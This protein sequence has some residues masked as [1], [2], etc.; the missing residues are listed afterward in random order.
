MHRVG[1]SS[2]PLIIQIDK[3][4]HDATPDQWGIFIEQG[5]DIQIIDDNIPDL[6]LAPYAMRMTSDMLQQLPAA[7]KLAIQGARTL[8]YAPHGVVIGKGKKG[9]K[10]TKPHKGRNTTVK[11]EAPLARQLRLDTGESPVAGSHQGDAVATPQLVRPPTVKEV[12]FS[13]KTHDCR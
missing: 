11:V 12:V 2:K 3:S 5:Y 1:K 4:L 8:R 13:S 9:V 10:T 7:L 6:Y